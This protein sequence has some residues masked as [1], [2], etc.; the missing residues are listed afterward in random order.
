MF[1]S[2]TKKSIRAMSDD[3]LNEKSLKVDEYLYEQYGM[4]STANMLNAKDFV[5]VLID[6]INMAEESKKRGLID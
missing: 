5:R 1:N 3:E 6:I 2:M 4:E